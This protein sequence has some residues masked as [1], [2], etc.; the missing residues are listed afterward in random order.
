MYMK[1]EKI[2]KVTKKDIQ[3]AVANSSKLEGLSWNKAKKNSKAIKIL[4]KYG[5]AFSI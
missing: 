3:K 2:K 5:R 4:K 1:P